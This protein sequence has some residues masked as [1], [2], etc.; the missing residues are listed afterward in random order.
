MLDTYPTSESDLSDNFD[1]GSGFVKQIWH[2][3]WIWFYLM[4]TTLEAWGFE[5][6]PCIHGLILINR[7][8]DYTSTFNLGW[9]SILCL[10]NVDKDLTT[11]ILTCV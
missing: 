10:S 11:W 2:K 3:W 6:V 8:K 4:L 5:P 7:G 9:D 1:I